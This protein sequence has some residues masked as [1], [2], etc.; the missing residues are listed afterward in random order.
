M[1]KYI[2]FLSLLISLPI[3]YGVSEWPI[4]GGTG[5]IGAVTGPGIVPIGGMF[6]M[7]KIGA[8]G[9]EQWQ[10]PATGVIK[11]G[12]MIADGNG[13]IPGSGP[14]A[15]LPVPNMS[16]ANVRGVSTLAAATGTTGSNQH[17][18][19]TSDLVSHNH[20][21]SGADN[22]STVTVTHAVSGTF[23]STTHK[24]IVAEHFSGDNTLHGYGPGATS[25]HLG[26]TCGYS[27]NATGTT[28][29]G[30]DLCGGGAYDYFTYNNVYS[31]STGLVGGTGYGSVS[32]GGASISALNFDH[33]HAGTASAVAT[34]NIPTV[35]VSNNILWLVRV[36]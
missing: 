35:P 31:A 14:L 33:T 21:Q 3:A 24:H 27:W 17:T 23:A 32:S 16:G 1:K 6:S 26:M 22:K 9:S 8:T 5:E 29:G 28:I 30:P 15:G 25:P 10:P 36:E 18:M 20:G 2:L 19:A 13:N 12:F 7:L 34:T 4:A 11:D